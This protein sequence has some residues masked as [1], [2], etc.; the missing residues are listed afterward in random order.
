MSHIVQT[1]TAIQNPNAE[2][3]QQAVALVAQQ[4]QGRVSDTYKNYYGQAQRPSTGLALF[5]P[6]LHRGIGLDLDEQGNLVFSGDPW[7][8]HQEFE[9]LQQEIVQ[10]FVSLATMQVFGQMGY[11][12]QAEDLGQGKIAIRG[13]LYA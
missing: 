9:R 5:T 2:L 7:G 1:K 4:H 10:S 11:Q 12:A 6:T 3:L 13:T 8:V